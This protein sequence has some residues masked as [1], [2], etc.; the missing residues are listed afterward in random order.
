LI[1]ESG[2]STPAVQQHLGEGSTSILASTVEQFS[3]LQMS[4]DFVQTLFF[5]IPDDGVLTMS[6]NELLWQIR[7]TTIQHTRGLL[8]LKV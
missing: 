8:Q 7:T 4:A 3:S 5:F 2:V 6:K 1:L